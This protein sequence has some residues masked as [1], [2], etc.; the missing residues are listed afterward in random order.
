MQEIGLA[1][2]GAYVVG[3][4]PFGLLFVWLFTGK[5]VRRIE[6]GRTGGTNA[7]RAAGF[8]A[9]LLTA[10]GDA[11]KGV[12]AGWIAGWLAPEHAWVRV[13]STLLAIVGHN[14]SLFLLEKRSKG[15]IRLR[16]GAGGA[17]AFGGAIALWPEAG[18]IIFPLAGL[19]YLL[20]GYASVTTMSV[21]FFSILI[22]TARA[23]LGLSPWIYVVYGFGALI[24][25]AWALRPNLARL[26]DG[27]ERVVGLRAYWQ[28]KRA[29]K[30]S[31]QRNSH[32]SR[33][34]QQNHV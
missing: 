11:F 33:Q 3:S 30:A 12:A 2:F 29:E 15:G 26:R 6:S 19:I 7:M 18:L 27:T 1:L 21:A 4:I 9:G 28:R 23:I 17:P 5:D 22:F 14:Y 25:V 8:L 31:R 16:G 10:A 24:I 32:P 34:H 20:V 13:A